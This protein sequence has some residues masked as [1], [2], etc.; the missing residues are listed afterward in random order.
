[1]VI[2]MAAVARATVRAALVHLE[3]ATISNSIVTKASKGTQSM[4]IL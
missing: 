4:C 2:V 1:M 3:Y